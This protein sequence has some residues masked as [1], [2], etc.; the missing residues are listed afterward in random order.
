MA[1]FLFQNFRQ[2][3]AEECR[4]WAG[5]TILLDLQTLVITRGSPISSGFSFFGLSS[6][7][8]IAT[9]RAPNEPLKIP[10]KIK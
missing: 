3:E 8:W 9:F 6:S 4:K 2:E 1:M 10:L 7:P 5:E